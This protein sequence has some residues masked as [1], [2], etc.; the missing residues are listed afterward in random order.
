MK[1]LQFLTWI[2]TTGSLASIF[3]G[4]IETS[5]IEKGGGFTGE[6]ILLCCF[7]F[8]CAFMNVL[9]AWMRLLDA[10]RPTWTWMSGLML[11][12]IANLIPI[13]ICLFSPSKLDK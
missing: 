2:T 12:P 3:W 6:V 4:F 13:C 1:R 7:L 11:I 5:R 9:S 8:L 10:G